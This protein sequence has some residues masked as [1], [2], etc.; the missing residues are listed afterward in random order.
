MK[1]YIGKWQL[2]NG[3]YVPPTGMVGGVDLRSIID[4]S[5]T[6]QDGYGLFFGNS[7][8]DS[9]YDFLG[10]GDIREIFSSSYLKSVFESLLGYKPKGDTLCALLKD[11]L[12]DGSDPE[13][14]EAVASLLPGNSFLQIALPEHGTVDFERFNRNHKHFDKVKLTLRKVYREVEKHSKDNEHRKLLTRLGIKYGVADPE[15][16]FIPK[17]LPKERPLPP[18]TTFTESFPTNGGD[19]TT[20]QDL[21][22]SS[23]PTDCAVVTGAFQANVAEAEIEAI[24]EAQH[25]LS[26]SDMY[27]KLSVSTLNASA[28]QNSF[29]NS[30]GV[31]VRMD[32]STTTNGYFFEKT[33]SSGG[34][35]RYTVYKYV[36]GTRTELVP[37]TTITSSL[38]G[39]LELQ[40]V[41]S[42]LTYV[43]EG[44][45]TD[46]SI[47]SNLRGGFTIAS[48]ELDAA[49]D[50]R[51]DNVEIS[52]DVDD[53][54]IIEPV[55]DIPLQT[56]SGKFTQ[57]PLVGSQSI[58]MPF[59]PKVIFF[60]SNNNLENSGEYL[61]NAGAQPNA[62]LTM[63]IACNSGAD[64]IYRQCS[65]SQFTHH[66][67]STVITGSCRAHT[68]SGCF[69]MVGEAS[70][71]AL[72]QYQYGII[73][74]AY[75]TQ[76]DTTT[77]VYWD[78][79]DGI[80]REIGFLAIGGTELSNF[81]IKQVNTPSQSGVVNYTG[82]GFQ[83]GLLFSLSAGVHDSGR[84]S[85]VNDSALGM[86]FGVGSGLG[87]QY[88]HSQWCKHVADDDFVI[89]ATH[90]SQ[91]NKHL[92]AYNY[93]KPN[94][95]DPITDIFEV[96]A[97]F[98]GVHS[99]GFSLNWDGVSGS[100]TQSFILA[101]E[102]NLYDVGTFK[103]VSHDSPT[104]PISKTQTIDGITFRPL[105]MMVTGHGR[106][107]FTNRGATVGSFHSFGVANEDV[108]FDVRDSPYCQL[109]YQNVALYDPTQSIYVNRTASTN[110]IIIENLNPNFALNPYRKATL[111]SFN[112]DGFTLDWTFYNGVLADYG[113]L[114][115]G[116][117]FAYKD[118][119]LSIRGTVGSGVANTLQYYVDNNN[120]PKTVEFY[121]L[122]GNSNAIDYYVRGLDTGSGI[123]NFHTVART[124]VNSGVPLYMP[125]TN[126]SGINDMFPMYTVGPLKPNAAINF[127]VQ[128][129]DLVNDSGI[130][131]M[132]VWG[133]NNSGVRDVFDMFVKTAPGPY[134]SINMFVKTVESGDDTASINMYVMGGYDKSQN[135]FPMYVGASG[136]NDT[137]KFFV[138]GL[139]TASGSIPYNESVNMV[140][141]S[142]TAG[143]NLDFY[144]AGPSGINDNI[145]LFLYADQVVNSG[146]N[147]SLPNVTDSKTNPINLFTRGF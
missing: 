134:S 145:Q 51:F 2:Q 34:L 22:W 15:N 78:Q 97:A 58:S 3:V 67:E 117:K 130:L 72:P 35:Q 24:V 142:Q 39:N 48:D 31:G 131:D 43:D 102:G 118:F 73:G 98:S 81:T 83:P 5:N 141:Y 96:S 60:Y 19:L 68:P 113:Y 52:D 100:G 21:T 69:Y 66:D 64:L 32:I 108:D 75:L 124:A 147:L 104:F 40:V 121:T 126:V 137:V 120:F 84:V 11:I 106:E 129:N 16:H 9:D 30:V 65:V 80:Q 61:F 54:I 47:V 99:D 143:N 79:V 38:T 63:G 46:T 45:T 111:S 76:M 91:S 88:A 101:M 112:N 109:Y 44:M 10:S 125:V 8:L 13:G 95:A 93:N 139:G 136:I 74:S 110:D 37:L 90:G 138:Q 6:K 144:L 29:I 87:Q 14:L 89:T 146:I 103:T 115:F 20:D 82:L 1:Y 127:F 27:T 123:L 57:S 94:N 4:Q 107:G 18:Q 128:T 41:G 23:N 116:S 135:S 26:D 7:S 42:T 122:G 36:G 86:G 50:I 49:G 25:D 59:K 92:I 105:A 85:S 114:L 70:G 53:P 71:V 33:H 132:F 119:D 55:R 133:T 28:G 77:K 62:N 140:L 12:T 17:G 56:Y